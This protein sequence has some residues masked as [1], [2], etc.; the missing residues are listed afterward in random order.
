MFSWLVEN[1]PH[2]K[3]VVVAGLMP[4]AV[5][6]GKAA[7]HIPAHQ[8]CVIIAQ[9]LAAGIAQLVALAV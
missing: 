4:H 6:V 7:V 3:F 2:G 8:P 1:L 5:L 9:F